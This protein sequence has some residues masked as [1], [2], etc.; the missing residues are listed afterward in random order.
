MTTDNSPSAP[1]PPTEE[2]SAPVTA[3]DRYWRSAAEDLAPAKSLARMNDKAKQVVTSVTLVGTLLAGFG[4]IAPATLPLPPLARGLAIAA[5][6]AAAVSIAL[7]LVSLLLRFDPGI[8]SSNVT[9]VEELYRSLFRRARLVIA[10]GWV[11]LLA[12]ALAAAAALTTLINPVRSDPL[13]ILQASVT[14]DGD[15]Q[16]TA[17]VEITGLSPGDALRVEL[18]DTDTDTR[19]V[20][21]QAAG[22]VAPN[23]SASLTLI[24]PKFPPAGT[25]ELA[26]WVPGRRCIGSLTVS[27]APSDA[28]A[29]VCADQG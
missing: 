23:G 20:I 8:R 17:R 3:R 26:V 25:A 21:G 9:E 1:P 18:A 5:V 24:E 19:T 4:L 16:V 22:Q 6:T 15:I 12:L 11:L 13:I 10:A 14:A 7:G 29:V 2:A 27:P 28:G